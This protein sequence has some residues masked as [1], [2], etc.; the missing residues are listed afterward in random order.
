MLRER[1]PKALAAILLL[2]LLFL[3]AMG[4]SAEAPP[5]RSALLVEAES[6]R[7]LFSYEPR[8][9]V[10]PASLVKMMVM[11][12][13]MER[14]EEGLIK[15]S[16]MVTVSAR[17]SRIGG[18]QVYLRQGEVMSLG[19][20]MKA[21]AIA[22]AN[23][24]SVAVAQYVAGMEETFLEL[25]NQR[26]KELGMTDTFYANVHGLPPGPGQR[27]NMTSARDLAILARELIKYPLVLKWGATPQDTFRKG[28]FLLTNTNRLVRT[29]PGVDGIKTG[30][31]RSAGYSVCATARRGPLRLIA[32]V[33]GAP[34]YRV[35]FREAARLLSR[36]FTMYRKVRAFRKGG[37]VGKVPVKGGTTPEALLVSAEELSVIVLRKEEKELI[38][39]LDIPPF[40]SAPVVPGQRVGKGRLI[41]RGK[42]L[43]EVDLL[44]IQEIPRESFFWRLFR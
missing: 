4:L 36:G 3:P 40:L 16:D 37:S 19:E 8:R 7:V 21:V 12:I 9:K 39:E 38:K 34:D 44:T 13:V 10:P 11:L 41:L 27:E 15:L 17:A 42:P 23:D 1:A 14:L 22:S 24:A 25:M 26:A 33:L 2:F 31:Y 20:L 32:I 6:G 5:Y 18:H 35:R 30:S 29:F 28:S 43:G